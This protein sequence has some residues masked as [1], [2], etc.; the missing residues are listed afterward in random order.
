M[1]GC[2]GDNLVTGVPGV[3]LDALKSHG[4]FCTAGGAGC[5]AQSVACCKQ[6]SMST[7]QMLLLA[8]LVDVEVRLILIIVV[9]GVA[10]TLHEEPQKGKWGF[11]RRSYHDNF[12]PPVNVDVLC[13]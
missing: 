12:L 3:R 11:D 8:Q 1:A 6:M 7:V 10:Y 5:R 13:A 4:W 9:G 2:L